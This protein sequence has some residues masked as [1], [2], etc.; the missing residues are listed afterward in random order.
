VLA[1]QPS[2]GTLRFFPLSLAASGGV[3]LISRKSFL[4]ILTVGA[5]VLALPGT[6]LA[7]RANFRWEFFPVAGVKWEV[8][9]KW[10]TSG[11][12]TGTLKTKPADASALRLEFISITDP[13]VNLDAIVARELGKRMVGAHNTA[14]VERVAQ[15]GLTGAMEF[16]EGQDISA[17]TKLEYKAFI[18]RHPT[19]GKGVLGIATWHKGDYSNHKG[20]LDVIFTSIQ[21]L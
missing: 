17:P 7:Q 1:A 14:P 10:I 6:A 8:P 4:S 15:W 18:L 13:T 16:G 3:M 5:G 9:N 19:S 2:A 21:P 11:E 12:G 20:Y